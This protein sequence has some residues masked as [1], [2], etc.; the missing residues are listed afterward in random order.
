[1]KVFEPEKWTPKIFKT[2]NEKLFL[3]KKQVRR[4]FELVKLSKVDTLDENALSS[5]KASVISR[6]QKTYKER[7]AFAF[8][9]FFNFLHLFFHIFFFD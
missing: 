2:L 3:Y 7:F 4:L 9:F 6:L 8:F 5:Y 1:M